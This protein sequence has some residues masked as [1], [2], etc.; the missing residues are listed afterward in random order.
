MSPSRIGDIIRSFMFKSDAKETETTDDSRIE[1][2]GRI[3]VHIAD[4]PS[5]KQSIRSAGV[6]HG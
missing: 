3:K 1:N 4:W 6:D 2:H 5:L